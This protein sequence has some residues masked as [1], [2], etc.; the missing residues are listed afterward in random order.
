MT[1]LKIREA[2]YKKVFILMM[3]LLCAGKIYAQPTVT[4]GNVT[5]CCN[6]AGVTV[7]VPVTATN[8]TG[9]NAL[10]AIAFFI[11]Y[12]TAGLVYDTVVNLHPDLA[13]NG[14]FIENAM[15]NPVN[16]V[17]IAWFGG[18]SSGVPIAS[19]TLFTIR[20]TYTCAAAAV[21]QLSFNLNQPTKT[22]TFNALGDVITSVVYTSGSIT[23]ANIGTVGSITGNA[24]VCAGQTN[25]QYSVASVSNASTYTW[26]VP[27]NASIASGQGTNTISVDY[28]N[29][30]TSGTIQVT[31]SDLCGNTN[32]NTLSVT[33]NPKPSGTG[34][35]T[36]DSP[37]CQG[38]THIYTV[39][40]ILNATSY[41]WTLPSGWNPS[42]G[43]NVTPTNSISITF[44]PTAATGPL[45]VVG[46]NS[47]GTQYTTNNTLSIT[48]N[49]M[50]TANAGGDQTIYN[51]QNTTLS[52]SATGGTGTYSWSWTP[53]IMIQGLTIIP[54]PTTVYLSADQTYTLVVTDQL[55]CVSLP[56]QMTVIILGIPLSISSISATPSTICQG[57]TSQ[58]SVTPSG[59]STT[60]T[61]TWAPAGSIQGSN[62][63]SNPV[64]NATVTTEYTVTVNDGSST[65]TGSVTVTVNPLPPATA[66]SNTPVCAQQTLNLTSGGGV[67]YD[68]S[69][70]NGFTSTSQNPSI[71]NVTTAASGTYTVTV[72]SSLG[73]TKT[74]T[75]TVQINA[76]PVPFATSNGPICSG[77]NLILTGSG[78]AGYSWT[79]PNSFSSTLQSP[80]IPAA[81]TL[82]SGTY[83]LLVTAGTGCQA[84]TTLPVTVYAL[85]TPTAS[86]DGPKCTGNTLCLNATG[87][88]SYN[89]SGPLGFSS[90]QQ[91]PCI[92]TATVSNSGTYTVTVTDA[93]SCS[94]TTTTTLT[95]WALPTPTAS[96][97]SPKCVGATVNLTSGGGTGY[98]WAGPDGFTSNLQNPVLTNVSSANGGTYTVT[99]TNANGCTNTTTTIVTINPLPTPIANNNGPKCTG[100]NVS[101]SASGGESYNWSGPG[102]FSSTLQ[103]PVLINTTSAM[104]G[105]YAVTVTDANGCS[106]SATTNVTVWDLPVPMAGSNSP[107]CLGTTLDLTAGGGN[108]YTWN[109]PS[110]TS[111]EQN[112]SITNITLGGAGTYNVTVTDDNGCSA[113]TSVTVVV[114]D[115][116]PAA[117]NSN[118]PVCFDNQLNLT[119]SGGVTYA[120]TGPNAFT[121]GNQNPSITNVTLAASGVY[122]V[123]VTDNHGC[124]KTA[125]TTV[126]INALPNPTASN[127]SPLCLGAT[128]NFSAAGGV[129]YAWSGPN[130][131]N[132]S[133]SNPSIN[134]AT[135]AANGLYS[136]TVTDA[137]TCK[138]TATTTVVVYSLP[139]PTI[140]SNTPL[141][142]GDNLD[143]TSG[144]GTNYIWSGPDGFSSN[145][146]FPF[147]NNVTL[148]NAGVYSVTVTDAHNC[149][150]TI[151]TT[152][153]IN[154]L[155][156]PTISSNSP[157]CAGATL[158]LSAGGGISYSWS[159]PNGFTS[160]LQN[161]SIVN[162]TI[163]AS[164]LYTVTVTNSNQCREEISIN[165]NVNEL[166]IANAGNDFTINYGIF[167]TLS[168]S[169]TGGSGNFS[170]N[171]TPTALLVNP[172]LQNPQTTNLTST[173]TFTLVVID[174]STQCQSLPDQVVVTVGGGPL[175]LVLTAGNEAIC[176][177][178]STQLNATASGGNGNYTY[179]WA[180][181]PVGFISSVSN[182]TVTPLVTTKYYVTISDG[183][184]TEN[185]SITITVWELPVAITTPAN[186]ELCTLTTLNLNGSATGGN[187]T[188][189][190]YAWSGPNSFN[191]LIQNPS[192]T[193]VQTSNAGTYSLTVT[194]ANGCKSENTA[195]TILVVNLRPSATASALPL[196]VCENESIQ[197][198][199]SGTG[200]TGTTYT[201]EWSG[202]DAFTSNIYNPSI[203]S[204][205]LVNNGTYYLTVT[206]IKGCSSTNTASVLI[207]VHAR[208]TAS[209]SVVNAE[210]C[211]GL[212]I[213]LQGNGSGGLPP[214]YAYNWS[215]PNGYTS[216]T[217]NS[218]ILDA[219]PN[220]SGTYS[221]TVTDQNNCSSVNPATVLVT[222]WARPTA[223]AGVTFT[224]PL[225]T[226]N[227]FQLQGTAT[228]GSGTGYQYSWTGPDN[229]TSALA[230]PSITN[231]QTIN[232]GTYLL[233]VTDN[234]NCASENIASVDV[235]V[236]TR[237][238]ASASVTVPAICANQTI[239]LIGNASGGVGPYTYSWTGPGTFTST[240]QNPIR[241]NATVAMTGTYTLNVT[242]SN[243]C[244]NA[245]SST[246]SVTVYARP[247]AV[248]LTSNG[249]I[250]A[251]N[252]IQLIGSAS[253]GSGSPYTYSWSG[254][255]SFTS[256]TQS[257]TITNA[258]PVATG[259]YCLTVSDAHCSS[260]NTACV[261]VTVNPKPL[262]T[263]SAVT[264]PICAGSTLELLG[265]GSGGS[266]TTYVYTWSG[267]SF[268]SS[269]QNPTI[270]NAQTSNGGLYSLFVKDG[271]TNCTS[272]LATITITVWSLP[273][274]TASSP[275]PT[276]CAN[277]TVQLIG[278]GSGGSG[279]GF[280]YEWGGPSGY[281]S[282]NQNPSLT[283]AQPNVTGSYCLTVTDSH[284]CKSINTACVSV[285]VNA[286][287]V[288][289]ASAIQTTICA[290]ESIQLT[291][292]ASGGN[293]A[294]YTYNWSGPVSY[295][296]VDQNP[297]I[298]NAQPNNS[299]TYSL[300]VTD[301]N[302][303]A[304]ATP[305]TVGIT[306]HPLPVANAGTD[307]SIFN[308]MY[309]SLNGNATGGTGQFSYAWSPA[310]MLLNSNI[311]NPQTVNLFSTQ[312]Y[313]LLATDLN[314]GCI[315]LPDQITVTVTGGV[316]SVTTGSDQ[317]TICWGQ[318]TNLITNPS[319]GAGNYTYSWT[320]VP[321][322]FTSS[323]QNPVI[324]PLVSTNYTV[325]ISD[326]YNTAS[327]TTLVT[328]NPLPEVTF[329]GPLTIQCVDWTIYPLVTGTP[330]GG[331]YSGSGVTGSNFNASSV[332]VGTYTLTYTYTDANTCTNS[333][334]RTIQVNPL[335]IVS[336]NGVLADQ[337]VSAEPYLLTG[338]VPVG[339]TYSGPGVSS[340]FF[341]PSVAGTGTHTLTYTYK[342]GTNCVNS[343]TNTI[344]VHALPVV[345]IN[346]TYPDQCY[347]ATSYTLTGGTPAGG[348]YSGTAVTG[349][350]FNPEQAGIGTYPI[351][352]HYTDQHSCT[353]STSIPVN[354]VFRPQIGG[355]AKYDN[356][357]QT[358]IGDVNI[359]LED[360]VGTVISSTTSQTGTGAYDFKCLY[361]ATFQLA[362]SSN[363]PTGSINS[364]DA[365]MAVRFGLGMITL[366][367]LRQVA[368][369][370]NG[371]GSWN[372]GDGLLIMKRFVG[373]ITT[374]PVGNWQFEI[375]N[376][377]P[378][379]AADEVRDILSICT[380]DV[381]GS[382][383]PPSKALPSVPFDIHGQMPT[384]VG[385]EIKIPVYAETRIQTSAISMVIELPGDYL[386][387]SG[388]QTELQ[389]SI[390]EAS[391]HEVR[392]AW[393]QLQPVTFEKGDILMTLRLRVLP[394]D[395]N[396]LPKELN[397]SLGGETEF[398]DA[399]A[400]KIE[401][402]K[403][404]V[405]KIILTDQTNGWSQDAAF[406]GSNIPNPFDYI[407][408][409]PYY[410]P[411]E[412]QVFLE[413]TDIFGKVLISLVDGEVQS[414][415]HQVSIDGSKLPP[416]IYLYRIRAAGKTSRFEES[417]KMVITR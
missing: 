331:T 395:Q 233:T 122:S 246:V 414:G 70:P 11:T 415:M 343:N 293:S 174:N 237:P 350:E 188:S 398:A 391:Q 68:W 36:G 101:L 171:W 269:S 162:A 21:S 210:I 371:N 223:T 253:G 126:L 356:V 283:N 231:V 278:S 264:N 7:N 120:W 383:I 147:I 176:L 169:G 206:D 318:S 131:F 133:T 16:Q 92:T 196:I 309:T 329:G 12:P 352:Y 292:T 339:G 220:Q 149:Q 154:A 142:V 81:S 410:L 14:F 143:L 78:G 214:N 200:G 404:G 40:G 209:A 145:D 2:M 4:I 416:G 325:V 216:S 287:P 25:V 54:N 198:T 173:T 139:V 33:V 357:P 95:V 240:D 301:A 400:V 64:A 69:G 128:I 417:K 181:D 65:K 327:S 265:T 8:F 20:F 89:W 370:V 387:L 374:F 322:G 377:V 394:T 367:P 254:P 86:N 208:P 107:V 241:P 245:S 393:Y 349:G 190:S 100:V 290:N 152:V 123:L 94:N 17:G 199:G 236:L 376:P 148:A 66:G 159:G 286:R 244:P 212:T 221:L 13:A 378:V 193:N 172:N 361:D 317:D 362:A 314:T 59:G 130:G 364:T 79:G 259:S 32:N 320:S 373:S 412:S 308:G 409:V 222:V 91:N 408:E 271:Q 170:W 298:A 363:K 183:Y 235:T 399:A 359:D 23:K 229:F 115:L 401:N 219:Q 24:T 385:K 369:D 194:D 67:S 407:T 203:T 382:Y 187:S 234:H 211:S 82:Y 116:P 266:N 114:Y 138:A 332:G 341:N 251:N 22:E 48:V 111:N 57:Q 156:V 28:G 151:N 242:G 243:Q 135:L 110:F 80:V 158:N 56:D 232:N 354:V 217:Q 71:S 348:W 134:N 76:L 272:T 113:S 204:A 263:V 35:I 127:N 255:N 146:Q 252:T 63:I 228:G 75:T 112:P 205:Q 337:C 37:V 50:P 157:I 330:V 118:T 260:V 335:P 321:A 34:T 47:C 342:D 3:A 195:T 215:G 119:S 9:S 256:T 300:T 386:S 396:M 262:A 58:L 129:I 316:L 302:N 250:C 10:G 141:C 108:L 30:A 77:S 132:A 87:G 164:G 310:G 268:S 303:C 319:G 258:Q 83:T 280:T 270:P 99:V 296:S 347:A 289:I 384:P 282:T 284:Q 84:S 405:P 307:F 38:T 189:Y 51:G 353:D 392:F 390:Y 45:T 42:S 61:Y 313:T 186:T 144:G 177:N 267:P 360:Q 344:V 184:N 406:L 140:S 403:L 315:S 346:A 167:T 182:P 178:K 312:T 225:C 224:A 299:G 311:Q 6:S 55:G 257:P 281:S 31:A 96:N 238:T 294:S 52:G 358:L 88:V 15:T 334:T 161:P 125:T 137:N 150:N 72:T 74:A 124:Q 104:T 368:A 230:N 49:P 304:S 297:V 26:T 249:T 411:E 85:P 53:A 29:T 389:G 323:Q 179:T 102:T 333:N 413:V 285:T 117:A 168:G 247:N 175:T 201:Y 197:F 379:N 98:Q 381:D 226:G 160:T 155:P 218:N 44:S 276:Q 324:S 261:S 288:A 366:A 279:G 402:Y 375:N 163:A 166:P 372:A 295:S 397:M 213:E 273:T 62:T 27:G 153:V 202:P 121:S 46:T 106:A 165:I 90:N 227:N 136:V 103:N 336:F 18:G 305:S 388:I 351:T 355:V 239:N 19:G 248:A 5:S 326:G 207:T 39:T 97:N 185:D 109:G 274:A 365:L 180:S 345:S 191:S 73:C 338:G 41:T 1:S 306:V 43:T 192:I 93:N 60:Y 380:G 275:G 328:V 340:G 277:N 105:T 291:G